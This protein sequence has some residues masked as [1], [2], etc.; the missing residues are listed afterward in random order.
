M[1]E[2]SN[3]VGQKLSNHSEPSTYFTMFEQNKL[4]SSNEALVVQVG[5]MCT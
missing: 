1:V 2:G 4:V 5:I 3:V